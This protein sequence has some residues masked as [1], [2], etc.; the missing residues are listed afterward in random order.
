MGRPF[1]CKHVHHSPGAT[2]FKPS[3]IQKKDLTEIVLRYEELESL[4]LC[5]DEGMNQTEAAQK[6]NV[7]QSTLQRTLARAREKVARALVQ[8]NALRIEG[9][10]YTMPN[11]D[12][13]GPRGEGPRTGRRMGNCPP[14]STEKPLGQGLGN[15]FGKGRGRRC[16]G[17]GRQNMQRGQ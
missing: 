5:D 7:H 6:M 3:G 4:R 1:K 16:Q 10:A 15:G 9:G 11:R 17:F 14:E 13:T 12:G 8:G 2:Y